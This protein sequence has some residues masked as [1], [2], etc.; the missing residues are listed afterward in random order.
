MLIEVPKLLDDG[1]DDCK[2]DSGADLRS[3]DKFVL[4][5][6]WEPEMACGSLFIE[7]GLPNEFNCKPRFA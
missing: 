4:V 2:F 3:G 6:A 7:S 5:V 1:F